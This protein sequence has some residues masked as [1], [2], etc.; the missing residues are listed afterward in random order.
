MGLKK[1]GMG[2][3]GPEDLAGR[4]AR[5]IRKL[6]LHWEFLPGSRMLEE[7]LSK[8]FGTSRVPIREAFRILEAGGL[9]EKERNKGYRV[10]KMGIRESFDLYDL[11]LALEMHVCEQLAGRVVARETLDTW[12][13][14]WSG[15]PAG[16]DADAEHFAD[17][18]RKFHEALAL[19]YGNKAVLKQLVDIN[20]Q[21]AF[22][23]L[24][25]F[26]NQDTIDQSRRDHLA[27][28]QAIADKKPPQA[29]EAVREN[30]L[31][32]QANVRHGFTEMLARSFIDGD[33]FTVSGSDREVR[34]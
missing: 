12:R 28:V 15:E 34:P 8:Q 14:L 26:E 30:I 19:E 27:I 21:I 31:Y 20:D 16:P 5:E 11:R 24:V 33:T 3:P 13:Q 2:Q 29:R 18:D 9:L 4:V 10:R 1:T 6:I 22:L 17:K 25:D 32:A 7:D 23:R